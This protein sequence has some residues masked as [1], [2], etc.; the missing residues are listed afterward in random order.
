[1]KRQGL[2]T[3]PK[4]LKIIIEELEAQCDL[5]NDEL[6][7]TVNNDTTQFQLNIINKQGLSDTWEFEK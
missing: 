7:V 5:L 1:M 6:G 4:E 3:T 2:I